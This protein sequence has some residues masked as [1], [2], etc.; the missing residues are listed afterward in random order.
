[1][2]IIVGWGHVG[3]DERLVCDLHRHRWIHLLHSEERQGLASV[4]G[5]PSQSELTKPLRGSGCLLLAGST[6]IPRQ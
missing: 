5:L 2:W 3:W 1:M 6:Q 4:Q